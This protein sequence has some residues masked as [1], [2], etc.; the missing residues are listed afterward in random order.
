MSV[1]QEIK[2]P[3]RNLAKLQDL[4]AAD[5]RKD[6]L[7]LFRLWNIIDLESGKDKINHE[8]PFYL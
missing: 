1:L 3:P 2:K 5:V 6:M 4:R 7:I 8:I